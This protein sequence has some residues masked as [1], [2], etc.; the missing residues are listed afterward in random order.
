CYRDG[1]TGRVMGPDGTATWLATGDAGFIT[2]DGRLE[3]SGRMPEVSATGAERVGPAAVERVL[4]THAGVGEVAVWKRAD[5]EW[6]ERVVAWVIPAD[7]ARPPTLDE[8][9]RWVAATLAPW[10]AP[11]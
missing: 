9:R 11:K 10:A 7:P 4:L 5:P 3:V 2:A 6:G 8:V 1:S